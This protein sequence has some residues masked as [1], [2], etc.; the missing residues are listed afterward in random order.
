MD[1]GAHIA[2]CEVTPALGLE[3]VTKNIKRNKAAGYT[4]IQDLLEWRE[5]AHIAIVGGGPS[6][7]DNLELLRKFKYVMACGS[8]HDYLIEQGIIPTWTAVVDPDPLMARYLTKPSIF[9]KYLVSSQCDQEVFDILAHVPVVL[10][11]AAGEGIENSNFGEEYVAIP[12]GCTIGT[13]AMMIAMMFGYYHQHLFGFD[14]CL[15]NEYD[16]HSYKFVDPDKESLGQIID[17]NLGDGKTFKVAG[18][19]L[20]QFFDFQHILKVY[21][22]KLNVT[23]HGEGLLKHL[24]DLASNKKDVLK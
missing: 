2:K 4:Q 8:V 21:A 14:T 18:Y 10:W 11:H 24:M 7:K 17:I 19:M 3:I 23:V 16:H 1:V 20:G 15:T 9:C 6:L 5:Q 12:G 22:R 13:R